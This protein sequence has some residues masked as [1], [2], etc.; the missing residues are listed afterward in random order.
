MQDIPNLKE[1]TYE[2]TTACGANCVMC[3]RTQYSKV[4]QHMSK[5]RVM[6]YTRKVVETGYNA[7]ILGGMGDPLAYPHIAWF[8]QYVKQTYP[9]MSIRL[10]TTGQLLTE[11]MLELVCRYVDILKISN[12]GFTKQIYESV[13]RGSLVFEKVQE[14]ISRIA[15]V[16]GR[17]PYIIMSY[18]DMDINHQE[19]LPWVEYWNTQGL[20]EVNVWKAHNWGGH[21]GA[22]EELSEEE[23]YCARIRNLHFK[24]WVDGTV[25]V[26]T[27]DCGRTL[28][29]G[30]LNEEDFTSI[31][32]RYDEIKRVHDEH[33]VL[34]STLDCRYCDQIFS[35][36][37]ALLYL[38]ENGQVLK[39]LI[40][41]EVSAKS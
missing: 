9:H 10:T 33:R 34:Q 25:S 28:V 16:Q 39:D 26:C 4:G 30:N 36:E 8:L 38:N 35:R 11:E 18:L 40:H 24:L 12:Y 19:V 7:I 31:N 23:V 37:E 27:F 3:A 41:T 22:R 17:R 20:S 32:Q 13:H 29:V 14:N 2:L 5:E 21:V 6:E 15:K 1:I